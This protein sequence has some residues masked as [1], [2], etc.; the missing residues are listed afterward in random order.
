MTAQQ[1]SLSQQPSR[2]QEIGAGHRASETHRLSG[3]SR[4]GGGQPPLS[5]ETAQAS[6]ILAATP[7][8]PEQDPA[9]RPLPLPAPDPMRDG[10]GSFCSKPCVW[11]HAFSGSAQPPSGQRCGPHPEGRAG[12]AGS[13][14]QTMRCP[15]GRLRPHGLAG[16][17]EQ[18]APSPSRS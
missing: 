1:S 10:Q 11:D 15:W 3:S 7:R 4:T 16:L 18:V 6:L 5:L 12:A 14:E 13:P 8:D 2:K 17:S 9:V